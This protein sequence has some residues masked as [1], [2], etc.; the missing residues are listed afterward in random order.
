MEEAMTVREV[1]RDAEI[2]VL[3]GCDAGQETVFRANRLTASV[4]ER[5]PVPD[6]KLEV[7]VDSGMGR[8]GISH[9]EAPAF[10][11][12]LRDRV[13]GVYSQFASSDS[14]PD[15]SRIQLDVFLAATKRVTCRRH[16][17]NSA[18][19]CFTA[20]YLDAV[21]PGLALYGIASCP[22]FS[23]LQPALTWKTSVLSLRRMLPGETVGYG[24]TFTISRPSLVAVLP[25]GYADGYSRAFSNNGQARVRGALAPVIGRVS[26]DLL[27]IDVTDVPGVAHGDEV[28]LLEADPQSPISAVA[29]AR[30]V[31]TIPYEI[32]TSIG[33]RVERIYV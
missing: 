13:T 32:I 10:L 31:G 11:D 27:S 29:L 22:D 33:T 24:R 3:T 8:L 9:V 14:D 15:F 19:L 16:I 2:L 28:T 20:A 25:I 23:H 6:V 4:F 5:G 26:M 17:A 21:R 1:V 30:R 18:A 7:K 12:E